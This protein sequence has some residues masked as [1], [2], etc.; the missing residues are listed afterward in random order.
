MQ[1]QHLWALISR[2]QNEG[3]TVNWKHCRGPSEPVSAETVGTPSAVE[4]N[5]LAAVIFE[6]H[7][8]KETYGEQK[9]GEGVVTRDPGTVG[10]SGFSTKRAS[11]RA[12]ISPAGVGQPGGAW[13]GW[14]ATE[15]PASRF[16]QASQA[17][18][19]RAVV[20]KKVA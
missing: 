16:H 12:S 6:D 9:R 15:M 10:C 19:S 13:T 17:K 3:N 18:G 8:P 14:G 1:L 11:G 4:S 5:F 7:V 2:L 20:R